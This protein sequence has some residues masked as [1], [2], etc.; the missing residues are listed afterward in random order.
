MGKFISKLVFVPP[1]KATP[2]DLE[3]DKVLTTKHH[4]KI[5]VKIIDRK[6][7]L[8]LLVSH[9]NAEDI[10]SVYDWAVNTLLEYVN[11]NVVIY[12]KNSIL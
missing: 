9:G 5:V 7:K 8:N 3:R 12:G 11:V 2:I 6:A 1:S 10:S 4:S